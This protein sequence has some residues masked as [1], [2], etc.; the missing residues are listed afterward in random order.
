MGYCP[1]NT[2][3]K[4]DLKNIDFPGSSGIP[5]NCAARTIYQ[6]GCTNNK[7]KKSLTLFHNLVDIDNA[8]NILKSDLKNIDFSESYGNPTTAPSG[9]RTFE[10]EIK[11]FTAR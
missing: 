10:D 1:A 7:W 4:A 8:N 3:L 2:I 11:T 6:C 9:R 5:D